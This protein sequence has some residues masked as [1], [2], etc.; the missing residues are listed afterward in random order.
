MSKKHKQT[1]RTRPKKATKPVAQAIQATDSWKNAFV[2]ASILIALLMIIIGALIL[3]IST[4]IFLEIAV[5]V[6]WII[7]CSWMW[8]LYLDHIG[9]LD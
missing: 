6:L 4:G 9:E 1:R 3:V 8:I 2:A 5:G 7:C